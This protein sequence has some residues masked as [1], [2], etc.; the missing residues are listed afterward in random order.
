M[1]FL[2]K[3]KTKYPALELK[4]LDSHLAILRSKKNTLEIQAVQKA[5][6]ITKISLLH[7]WQKAPQAKLENEL[8]AELTYSYQMLGADHAFSPIVASGKNATILHYTKNKAL[9]Q[10]KDLLLID[11]GA[12]WQS[13][14]SD[15][16]RVIP[17]AKKFSDKQKKYYETCAPDARKYSRCNP[18]TYYLVGFISYSRRYTR[19]KF[20]KK[21]N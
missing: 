18:T 16:T 17:L 20:S 1:E 5:I 4:K 15:I 13:Y 2:Q 12:I 9:L 7:V 11:T 14:N 10:E 6:E 3:I 19:Q 21:Q 8:E